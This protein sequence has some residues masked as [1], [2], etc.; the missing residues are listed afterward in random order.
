M[1]HDF[2]SRFAETW[3]PKDWG[4]VTVLAAVS[5]GADSVALLRTL[6]RLKEDGPGRIGAVH[7]NHHLRLEADADEQFVRE[8]CESLKIPCKFGKAEAKQ[9]ETAPGE[10]IE[11]S[12]RR[13]RYD[14]FRR[15]A[16]RLGARYVVTAHTADDQAETILHRILRGTG[17]G[18][19]SGMARTRPLGHAVLIRPLLNFRRADIERYLADLGQPFRRDASNFDCRYTRNRIRHELLPLLTKEYNAQAVE[20]ILRLG[21]LA[22]ESQAVVDRAV[23]E[24][25]ARNVRMD[26][27]TGVRIA[28]NGLETASTHLLRELMM[29]V[30]RKKGWPLQSMGFEEWSLLEKMLRESLLL[31]PK[32]G[33]K[34]IFPGG[35][36]VETVWGEMKLSS[37]D[38]LETT[39]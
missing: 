25:F 3:P 35:I 39:R 32:V 38:E 8:L 7:F 20:A 14:F 36:E 27:K 10:G 13:L 6:V 34:R 16:G 1:P 15:A 28:S 4:D 9:I 37:K 30:W 19:L 33:K 17:I 21:S 29:L 24:L 11:E 31:S 22:G 26:Y 23:E 12:A 5:G 18:G 2:E